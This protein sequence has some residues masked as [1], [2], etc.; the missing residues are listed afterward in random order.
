V[1]AAL[2]IERDVVIRN[3]IRTL[4]MAQGFEML[5]AASAAEAAELSESLRD[6]PL[7][8]VIIDHALPGPE[9][10]AHS[11]VVAKVIQGWSPGIRIL[12][13]S[14]CSYQAV[15]DDGLPDGA[16]F[17]QKPFTATQLVDMV[18]NI[19]RPSIQ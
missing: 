12:V 15:Y 6:P 1:P 2:V 10:S 9:G 17:L 16:W 3:F 8:L 4:L 13:I 14:D 11:R 7:D 5:D 19:L 18:K